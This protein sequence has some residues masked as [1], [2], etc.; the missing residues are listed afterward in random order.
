MVGTQHLRRLLETAT[1]AGTKVV[2]VGDEHQLA[3]VA[4][5]GGTFAQLVTDLPWAQRLSQV[6]DRDHDERNASLAIP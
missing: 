1:A 5:R 4:Q 3:P 2:L 6:A